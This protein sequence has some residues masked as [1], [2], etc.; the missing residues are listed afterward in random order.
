MSRETFKKI[1][2]GLMAA[3]LNPLRREFDN[4]GKAYLHCQ[5]IPPSSVLTRH[6]AYGIADVGEFDRLYAKAVRDD[7]NSERRKHG[8]PPLQGRP[9]LISGFHGLKI[10]VVGPE[11]GRLGSKYSDLTDKKFVELLAEGI[12]MKR[13]K[14]LRPSKE[15]ELWEQEHD[16]VKYGDLLYKVAYWDLEEHS[17]IQ[18]WLITAK[19]VNDIIDSMPP[20]SPS[21]K[22]DYTEEMR[23]KTIYQLTAIYSVQLNKADKAIGRER[24]MDRRGFETRLENAKLKKLLRKEKQAERLRDYELKKIGK[25]EVK[26]TVPETKVETIAASGPRQRKRERIDETKWCNPT[27]RPRAQSGEADM[28]RLIN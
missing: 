8:F 4:K 12:P 23:G 22:E 7:E 6:Q 20:L 25:E 18:T 9:P 11:P 1:S 15:R 10:G 28:K 27:K 24:E 13:L 5:Q 26:S 21:L 17:Y 3:S 16:P 19:R 2:N 14:C